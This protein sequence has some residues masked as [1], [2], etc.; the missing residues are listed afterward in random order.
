MPRTTIPFAL[1]LL[2]IMI[3][4]CARPEPKPLAL[5]PGEPLTKLAAFDQLMAINEAHAQ[6]FGM[7]VA[8]LRKRDIVCVLLATGVEIRP[9]VVIDYD[10]AMLSATLEPEEYLDVRIDT[11][12]A[13]AGV[14]ASQGCKLMQLGWNEDAAPAWGVFR[15]EEGARDYLDEIATAWT[16]LGG[17]LQRRVRHKEPEGE[18]P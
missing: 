8:E 14:Y 7:T 6:R 3:G 13:D 16:S 12:N 9:G 15:S 18:Q 17:T 10:Q 1:L 4:G 5:D 11:I 2:V